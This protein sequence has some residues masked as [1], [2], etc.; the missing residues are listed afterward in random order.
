MSRVAYFDCFSGISGDMVLG[1][2]LACGAGPAVLDGVVAALGLEEEVSIEVRGEERGHLAGTRVVVTAGDGSVRALPELLR[3]VREAPGLSERVR[4]RSLDALELLG[5]AESRVHGLP[6]AEIHLHELG[7]ADTLVDLVGS[8]SLLESL[9][10]EE[11]YCSPLPAERGWAG[12]LPLPAPAP[13]WSRS[14]SRWSWSPRPAPR[15]SPRWHA[16]RGLS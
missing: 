14:R 15:S 2:L 10:V 8:F 13:C 11:L 9:G 4:T 7:G 12:E 3:L 16:S 1:A 6:A 5:Q